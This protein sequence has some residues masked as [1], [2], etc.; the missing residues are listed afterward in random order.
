MRNSR[1]TT[2]PSTIEQDQHTIFANSRSD[3]KRPFIGLVAFFSLTILALWIYQQPTAPGYENLFL[4]PLLLAVVYPL[5]LNRP[6]VRQ[7]NVFIVVFTAVVAVRF[8]ILPF[9]IAAFSVYD[10]RAVFQPQAASQAAAINLMLW[11]LIVLS[12]SIR[13]AF[14]G[15]KTLNS[16]TI[17]SNPP[18]LDN[19][20]YGIYPIVGSVLVILPFVVPGAINDMGFFSAAA[21]TSALDASTLRSFATYSAIIGKQLLFIWLV[22]RLSILHQ[23]NP[24][25][26]Y[27]TIAL[28][29][30]ILNIGVF[31]G[32][33][34]SDALLPLIATSLLLLRLFGRKMLAPLILLGTAGLALLQSI[35]SARN[36]YINPN[37]SPAERLT[38]TLSSYLGG[39][40]NVAIA[41]ESPQFYHEDGSLPILFMDIFRGMLGPNLLLKNVDIPYSNQIFNSRMF[42]GS[43]QETQIMPIVGQ[44][45][46]HFGFFLA[47]LLAIGLIILA[48]SLHYLWAKTSNP[49][50]FYFLTLALVRL[51]LMM[52]QNTTNIFNDLS[53]NLFLFGGIYILNRL[54]AKQGVVHNGSGRRGGPGV[55]A[56]VFR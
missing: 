22:S 7:P 47:P 54:I 52:G 48:R 20:E 36:L 11:E 1:I 26:R 41:I 3:S 49:F 13:L 8:A 14:R 32:L 27:R 40:H 19:A 42:H 39:P 16:F 12:V 31:S 28:F 17:R 10:G 56:E 51:G 55:R 29:L 5:F 30:A 37:L 2:R 35:S 53:Q 34:R 18:S 15:P 46:F 9:L 44:G 43:G 23:S 21:D 25:G 50:V 38:N 33:N 24:V 6:L 4:Q 45:H